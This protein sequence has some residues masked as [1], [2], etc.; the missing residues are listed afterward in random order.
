MEV[1]KVENEKLV[2]EITKIKKENTDLKDKSNAYKQEVQTLKCNA[3]KTEKDLVAA[4]KAL[5]KMDDME[6]LNRN[7][8]EEN[9]ILKANK[10]RYQKFDNVKIEDLVGKVKQKDTEI[11]NLYLILKK[12][13]DNGTEMLKV[14]EKL[15][16]QVKEFKE[17]I[18]ITVGEC[19]SKYKPS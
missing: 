11:E 9:E 15:D 4:Q 1:I 10:E 2:G 8:V 17:I 16:K 6:K 19:E 7:V 18:K 3:S 12:N 5:E 14:N 13:S